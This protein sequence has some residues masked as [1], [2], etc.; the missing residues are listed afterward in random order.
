[1][2]RVLTEI[3][4][5]SSQ[6]SE[7]EL[8]KRRKVHYAFMG[9]IIIGATVLLSVFISNMKQMVTLATTISF[10]TAPVL[11]WLG[12]RVVKT[13]LKDHGWSKKIYAIAI[14]GVTFLVLFSL[15]YIVTIV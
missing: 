13:Q 11:A 15:Y 5:G 6:N 9:L 4:K 2:P 3:V 1:M 7:V 12:I 10:L 8:A 14:I